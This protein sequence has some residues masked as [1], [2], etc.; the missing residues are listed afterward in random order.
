[1]NLKGKIMTGNSVPP[2]YAGKATAY[3]DQNVLDMAVD[4]HDPAFF[5]SISERFQ[6]IYSDETLREIKRSGQPDK[7][8]EALDTLKAMHFRY[9]LTPSFEPTGDMILHEIPSMQ[10]YRNYLQVAPVYDTIQAAAHQTTLKLYGGRSDS[11][12][13]DIASEQVDAF[14]GLIRS[15][16]A[17]LAELDHTHPLRA[18][19]EQYLKTLQFQYEQISAVA[20][21][22]MAKHINDSNGQ[23][24][25][26]SY[27]STVGVGPKQLNNIKPPQVIEKIWKAHQQLDGYRD[28][29]Y[30]IEDFLGISANPIYNREMHVHEQVTAIYN[31]L[32]VIGYKV[33][34]GMNKESRHIAAISDAAHAAI[35]SRAHILLSADKVFVDK[36]RAIYEF[37]GV[38]TQI[39]LISRCSERIDVHAE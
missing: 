7:F 38:E 26:N 1:V 4:G 35:G 18:P 30:S 31:L 27:R 28:L 25:V 2:T 33:D 22:E 36:V 9:Q 12:F 29:G 3:I 21:A 19:V 37:L 20:A 5:T 32:N 11:T 39:L 34:S 10:S 23:S 15:L 6:I 17:P 14:D 13:T 16:S 8:L 24:G